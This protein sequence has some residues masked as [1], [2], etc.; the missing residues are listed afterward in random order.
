MTTKEFADKFFTSEAFI[1]RLK[2][3]YADLETTGLRPEEY[4][5]WRIKTERLGSMLMHQLTIT[6]ST[7][8]DGKL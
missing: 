2:E 5:E 1:L 6:D 7:I 8:L 3:L 4:E